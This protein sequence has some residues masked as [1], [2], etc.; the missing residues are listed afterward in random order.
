MWLTEK[1]KKQENN[2]VKTGVV[3]NDGENFSVLA[4]NSMYQPP[5]PTPFGMSSKLPIGTAV[6]VK[7]EAVLGSFEQPPIELEN[8]E[9]CLYSS[10]GALI[11]LKNNGEVLIN[12][13]VFAPIEES[14]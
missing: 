2:V 4:Q 3:I 14:V 5:A 9:I 7:E 10:G 11:H 1:F 12:G 13:Q 8:G 6:Y